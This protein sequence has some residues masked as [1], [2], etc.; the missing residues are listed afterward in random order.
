MFLHV[1]FNNHVLEA[2]T[3]HMPTFYKPFVFGGCEANHL[4]IHE[5]ELYTTSQLIANNYGLWLTFHTS[6]CGYFHIFFVFYGQT[7]AFW[8]MPS[9]LI[10]SSSFLCA[11]PPSFEL[12]PSASFLTFVL[13][14]YFTF[15]CLKLDLEYLSINLW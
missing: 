15:T 9:A 5:I 10:Y 8:S 2:I 13:F 7:K 12:A 6:F 11:W 14:F 1:S 4:N 3:M